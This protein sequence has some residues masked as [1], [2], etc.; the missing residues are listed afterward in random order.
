MEIL[1]SDRKDGYAKLRVE[2]EDDL[3][4]LE[5]IIRPGDEV[6]ALTQRT[7]LE[8][9]EKKT[10]KLS[11]EAEKI[12]L[13]DE[14]LRV[15]GEITRGD[16]DIELGYHTFNIEA[17]D[18]FE[19]W[20]DG[21]FGDEAWE[22]LGEAESSH[23]Y[24]VLFCLVEKGKADFYLVR[25]SGI[26]DLSSLEQNIPGKL[27]EDQDRGGDFHE[28]VRNVLRRSGEEVG[29]IVLAG[30]G[31]EKDK[32]YE[33]LPEEIENKTFLQDTSVTGETGL[34]EAIKRGALERVVESSR[35]GDESELVEKFLEEL[36]KKGKAE[37]G[38]P[39]KELAE[40]GAVK[41]L[42]LTRQEFREN[43]D[44]VE[45]VEQTGGEVHVI[46]TDHES[47]ER[48]ENFGGIAAILRYESG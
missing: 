6:R 9:R 46:H 10:L 21:G 47:G 34:N 16:E 13:R 33:L 27:Y 37:Y 42:L 4:H 41:E 5:D 17:G 12:E 18:E 40:Q 25:E 2:N 38:E 35:I 11:L 20:R 32:V 36:E 29:D 14:R 1:K 22:R 39:V 7:K 26:T 45:A 23:S 48:L 31:F 8:G 44:L 28:E 24:E 19:F 30:P 15:T 3:W 43:Q